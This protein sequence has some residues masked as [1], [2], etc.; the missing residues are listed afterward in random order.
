MKKSVILSLIV[1]TLGTGCATN[2]TV[3][4]YA[5]GDDSAA[6]KAGRNRRE[7]VLSDAELAQHRR[8]RQNVSEEMALEEQK[9]QRTINN[10]AAPFDMARRIGIW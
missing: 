9:R 10:I 3:A 4:Q 6:I 5:M 2:P 8:Q 1:M 7:A